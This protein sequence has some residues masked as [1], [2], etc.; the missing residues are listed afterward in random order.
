MRPRGPRRKAGTR[1]PRRANRSARPETVRHPRRRVRSPPGPPRGR[2]PDPTRTGERRTA[3]CSAPTGP[4][5][6]RLRPG[7]PRGGAG[8][9]GAGSMAGD[10]DPAGSHGKHT[11]QAPQQG[12]LAGP[13]RSAQDQPLARPDV[14]RDLA[15]DGPAAED[16]AHRLGAD[17]RHRR[18]PIV[19][20]PRS[21]R[22]PDRPAPGPEPPPDPGGTPGDTPARVGGSASPPVEASDPPGSGPPGDV[23]DPR[24]VAPSDA[25]VASGAGPPDDESGGRSGAGA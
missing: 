24:S 10:G 11:G 16:A 8:G 7:A 23:G 25:G 3:G 6:G 17:D 20:H 18:A 4:Q 19:R 21:P 22:S 2:R 1:T 5:T 12:G 14:R 9:P 15:E 13:V